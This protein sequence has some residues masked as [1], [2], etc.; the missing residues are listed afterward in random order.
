MLSTLALGAA[1]LLNSVTAPV[2]SEPPIEATLPPQTDDRLA[3][4]APLVGSWTTAGDAPMQEVWMPAHGNNMTGVLRWYADD[5]SV[6]MWELV[7]ITAEPDAVRMR[8]RHFDTDVNPWGS[9]ADGPMVLRLRGGGEKELVFD[10]EHRSGAVES[11]TY[12]I[13]QDRSLSVT[14]SFGEERDPN[15]IRF[16]PME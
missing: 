10:A 15:V 7:T 13:E 3:A 6:R 1:L 8:I 11:I 2:S 14:L 16:V 4:F 5:G 12:L 9:E